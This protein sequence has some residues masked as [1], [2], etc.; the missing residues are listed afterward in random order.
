[1][2]RFPIVKGGNA[3]QKS[4]EGKKKSVTGPKTIEPWR[5]PT[6]VMIEIIGTGNPS[7]GF[8]VTHQII[9]VIIEADEF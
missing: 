1:M 3:V 2:F 4:F 7:E 8:G 6:E 5:N 9:G